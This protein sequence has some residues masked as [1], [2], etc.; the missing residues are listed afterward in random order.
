MWQK[1]HKGMRKTTSI[2]NAKPFWAGLMNYFS[3]P[4]IFKP[5]LSI[6]FPQ[7]PL[8]WIFCFYPVS[9]KFLSIVMEAS[10]LSQKRGEKNRKTWHTLL[11]KTSTEWDSQGC[12]LHLEKMEPRN[13]QVGEMF[14]F[15]QRSRNK[16]FL[17]LPRDS[18]RAH[19]S[20]HP[21]HLSPPPFLQGVTFIGIHLAITVLVPEYELHLHSSHRFCCFLD[22]FPSRTPIGN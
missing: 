11:G 9:L 2:F 17:R 6:I 7:F 8:E 20:P 1:P 19:L 12:R 10:F 18:V 3:F 4:G 21:P 14:L 22:I 15:H 5:P 16:A 13:V